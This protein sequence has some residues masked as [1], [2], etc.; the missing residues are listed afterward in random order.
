VHLN[1]EQIGQISASFVIP[2][3]GPMRPEKVYHTP[4]HERSDN[5]SVQQV[6]EISDW[7]LVEQLLVKKPNPGK[8]K[9]EHLDAAR[10][11]DPF[12][13]VRKEDNDA[14]RGFDWGFGPLEP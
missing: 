13:E 2:F 8:V 11:H 10:Q 5:A 3:P 6:N 1:L 4:N 9:L 14:A 12:E 7:I